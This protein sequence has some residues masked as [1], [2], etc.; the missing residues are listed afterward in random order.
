[1]AAGHIELGKDD[2]PEQLAVDLEKTIL[3]TL[4]GTHDVETK[5][6]I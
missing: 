1:M 2:D 3:I 5:P 4:K 6:M